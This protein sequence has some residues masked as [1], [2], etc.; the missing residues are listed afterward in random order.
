MSAA[1]RKL[2][3]QAARAGAAKRA[4]EAAAP[5][6]RSAL[7]KPSPSS[8]RSA[9]QL[10]GQQAPRPPTQQVNW[11]LRKQMARSQPRSRATSGEHPA[12]K[13]SPPEV[14]HQLKVGAAAQSMASSS[15]PSAAAAAGSGA[16]GANAFPSAAKMTLVSAAT[17]AACFVVLGPAADG[18]GDA[19]ATA[20]A[21]AVSV[22]AALRQRQGG[23]LRAALDGL[24]V[25]ELEE[26]HNTVRKVPPAH[27]HGAAH[28]LAQQHSN[29]GGGAAQQQG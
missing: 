6:L 8:G 28:W 11:A 9:A 5:S 2:A 25:P 17:A 20:T 24:S 15:M 22:P 14:A 3:Q 26:I 12:A 16:G 23:E 18:G 7:T 19:S 29:N 13:W 27:R 21:P 4:P 1:V 10:R